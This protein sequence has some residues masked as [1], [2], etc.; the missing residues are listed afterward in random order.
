MVLVDA[1]VQERREQVPPLEVLERDHH[2]VRSV[3]NIRVRM[4]YVMIVDRSESR[5]ISP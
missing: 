2:C 3:K 1:V 4:C 5:Y